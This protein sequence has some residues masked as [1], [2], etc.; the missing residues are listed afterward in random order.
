MPEPTTA[1]RR[2]RVRVEISEPGQTPRDVYFQM[3][4]DAQLTTESIARQLTHSFREAAAK[5]LCAMPTP[6]R[7]YAV[8]AS[9]S[10]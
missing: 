5:A 10:T 4:A 9:R 3:T 2:F 8:A 1:T 7:D 6:P